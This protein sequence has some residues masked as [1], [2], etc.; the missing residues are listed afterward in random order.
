MEKIKVRLN[1]DL[2]KYGEGLKK[3]IEG[4]TIGEFGMWSRGSDR[5]VGVCFPGIQTVDV[6]WDSLDII[7]EEFLKR[8]EESKIKFLEDLKTATEVEKHIGPRGG[9]R[10]LSYHYSGG[11]VSNAFKDEA[12]EIEKILESYGIEVKEIIDK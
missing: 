4:Y 6:L 8:R 7:D 9:F 11:Y 12:L 1:T 5:F 10:Y 2:T 3:G